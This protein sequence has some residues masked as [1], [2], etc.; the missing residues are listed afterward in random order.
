MFGKYL[1]DCFALDMTNQK[2]M[3]ML[4][5]NKP[6][7]NPGCFIINKFLYVLFGGLFMNKRK[8]MERYS[9]QC[10]SGNIW[11]VITPVI[12]LSK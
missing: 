12:G 10:N 4:E 3:P 2:W 9:L 8:D 5:L 6:R 7:Y 11:E 1:K